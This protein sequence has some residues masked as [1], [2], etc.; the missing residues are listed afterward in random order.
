M[1]DL[2]NIHYRRIS[3]LLRE[4]ETCVAVAVKRSDMDEDIVSR[5]RGDAEQ[6]LGDVAIATEQRHTTIV[7]Q[8]KN[9]HQ[10]IKDETKNKVLL[11]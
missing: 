3:D 10:A 6:Y 7:D 5:E 9:V 11:E 1:S 4:H 2:Q 8:L